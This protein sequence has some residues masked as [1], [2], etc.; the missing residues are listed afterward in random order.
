[1]SSG[2]AS[3]TRR[4]RCEPFS[5]LSLLGQTDLTQQRG[6][7]RV[8]AKGSETRV[9]LD[10]QRTGATQA[11]RAGQ[12][13]ERGLAVAERRVDHGNGLGKV[14]GLRSGFNPAKQLQP[15]L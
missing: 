9:D 4:T 6:E 10:P 5:P 15:F 8:R 13:I 2:A 3:A 1:M 11:H 12:Q 7:T 14:L